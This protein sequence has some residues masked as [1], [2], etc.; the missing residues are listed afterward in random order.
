MNIFKEVGSASAMNTFYTTGLNININKG[1]IK[2]IND[3]RIY[4][5]QYFT[6]DIFSVREHQ[7]NMILGFH[8]GLKI[9]KT[10]LLHIHRHDVFY[11]HDINGE[12]DMN[13]THGI[14]LIAKF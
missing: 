3:F 11:D 5:N 12:T 13:S 1:V 2:G 4:F 10:I 8:L 6:K 9:T 14:K 7:E